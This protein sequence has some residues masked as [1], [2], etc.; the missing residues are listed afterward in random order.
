MQE[1]RLR[2]LV[3]NRDSGTTIEYNM[4]GKIKSIGDV[5]NVNSRVVQPRIITSGDALRSGVSYRNVACRQMT[6]SKNTLTEG[7]LQGVGSLRSGDICPS[8][9]GGC[10][11]E[12]LCRTAESRCCLRRWGNSQ[13]V[14]S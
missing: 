8:R 5:R 4:G 11:Q 14:P 12:A 3:G 10:R 7:E 1:E 6:N 2:M 9:E 13:A